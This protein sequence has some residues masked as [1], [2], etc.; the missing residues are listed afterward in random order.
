MVRYF[1]VVGEYFYW[2][3]VFLLGKDSSYPV[4]YE[5]KFCNHFDFDNTIYFLDFLATGFTTV[6]YTHLLS[7]HCFGRTCFPSY[8]PPS[9]Q[10]FPNF[11]KS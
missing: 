8:I 9:K 10:H 6:S 1:L 7:S 4:A 2:K 11:I 3:Y 5:D